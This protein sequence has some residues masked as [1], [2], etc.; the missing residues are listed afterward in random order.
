MKFLTLGIFGIGL[1]SV[2]VK[3]RSGMRSRLAKRSTTLPPGLEMW[4]SFSKGRTATGVM[5]SQAITIA[6]AESR[7]EGLASPPFRRRDWTE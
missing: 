2:S 1:T 3:G 7:N 6:S 5:V 4:T